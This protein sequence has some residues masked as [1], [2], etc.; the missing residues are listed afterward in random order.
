DAKAVLDGAAGERAASVYAGN[1]EAAIRADAIGV[2][3]YVLNG[4]AFWGQDRLDLLDR[5]LTSGRKP[6][7]P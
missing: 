5:A 6:Y 1:T 4:E 2:P 3:T 7:L